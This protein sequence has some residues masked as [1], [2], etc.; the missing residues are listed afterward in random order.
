LTGRTRWSEARPSLGSGAED[1]IAQEKG[2]ILREIDSPRISSPAFLG[3]CDRA[4]TA[5]EGNTQLF[6]WNILGL[7]SVVLSHIFPLSID[8]LRFGLAFHQ[9]VSE[10]DTKLRLVSA[11]GEEMGTFQISRRFASELAQSQH[12]SEAPI[13]AAPEF[14]WVQIP[15]C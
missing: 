9:D 11:T 7:R 3:V 12:V 2:E 15:N 10:T 6:K 5:R 13:L 4:Q 14:G 1:R 8:G